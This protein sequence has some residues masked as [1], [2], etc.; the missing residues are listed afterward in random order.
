MFDDS[1]VILARS[2]NQQFTPVAKI[3]R[4]LGLARTQSGSK[5]TFTY[6]KGF[7]RLY[8]TTS[9]AY[10]KG[11]GP[12]LTQVFESNTFFQVFDILVPSFMNVLEKFYGKE[13]PKDPFEVALD[14]AGYEFGGQDHISFAFLPQALYQKKSLHTIKLLAKDMIHASK[15]LIEGIKKNGFLAGRVYLDDDQYK[16]T[17]DFGFAGAVNANL[18]NLIIQN[19][20][21][22]NIGV[23]NIIELNSETRTSIVQFVIIGKFIDDR[24][25]LTDQRS[26]LYEQYAY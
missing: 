22:F 4:Y 13:I 20:S 9:G 10:F 6:L 24:Q 1:I 12:N 15:D 21:S 19:T 7:R 5:Y 14:F 18:L 25:L 23:I 2:G 16:I 3:T 8:L 26:F 17:T 11:L